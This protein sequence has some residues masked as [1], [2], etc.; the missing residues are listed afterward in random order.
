MN[1]VIILLLT[2]TLLFLSLLR[3][4]NC[5]SKSTAP[6]Y[7]RMIYIAAG[8]IFFIPIEI[9]LP[10]FLS[11]PILLILFSLFILGYSCSLKRHLLLM[12]SYTI[13]FLFTLPAGCFLFMVL[14]YLFPSL[15]PEISFSI[16]FFFSSVLH[17]LILQT[18]CIISEGHHAKLSFHLRVTLMIIPII[19]ASIY[20]ITVGLSFWKPDPILNIL[21]L[22]II[23]MVTISCLLHF[24]VIQKFQAVYEAEHQNELLI[25][26]A[27]LK[28]DYYRELELS[29]QET[30]RIRH[31]LCNQLAGLYDS[32]NDGTPAA[33]QKLHE[34]LGD[35]GA[36]HTKIYTSN[37]ILNS[38]LKLKFS[39][40]EKAH[41]NIDYDIMIPK[42]LGIEYGDMGILFGNLL[43]N[44]IEACCRIPE[45]QRWI[46]VTISYSAG[47]LVLIIENSKDEMEDNDLKTMKGKTPEH[48]I[49]TKSIRKVVEKY[50]GVIEFKDEAKRFE[51]S[52]IIY[53]I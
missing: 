24:T 21:S 25:Q 12:L 31:D 34:L 14:K 51:A 8:S 9:F 33:R 13:V 27:A 30:C 5:F 20:I 7:L 35:L 44:A 53:G 52:A 11:V 29:Q 40:A 19:S 41:I 16:A 26:E 15:P 47:G 18:V 22:S 2:N 10:L 3:F 23:F 50:D 38:I 6:V 49:G 42:Y 43:D 28:E 36:T 4:M 45:T 37:E 32:L 39:T 48:G 17:F 1:F 46:R